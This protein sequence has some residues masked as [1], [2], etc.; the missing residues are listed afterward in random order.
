MDT[1]QERNRYACECQHKLVLGVE[2]NLKTLSFLRVKDR[3]SEA[4]SYSF[5]KED[6]VLYST[7]CFTSAITQHNST[8][9]LW[10]VSQVP[11]SRTTVTMYDVRDE[12]GIWGALCGPFLMGLGYSQHPFSLRGCTQMKQLSQGS[13]NLGQASVSLSPLTNGCPGTMCFHSGRIGKPSS[14]IGALRCLNPHHK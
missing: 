7:A 12:D 3:S 9:R 11:L 13:L 1:I 14:H 5:S 6:S 2:G 10:T 4:I 8:K